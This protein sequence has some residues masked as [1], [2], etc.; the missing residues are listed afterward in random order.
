MKYIVLT[1]KA[2]IVSAL[3]HAWP[4]K[5]NIHKERGFDTLGDAREFAKW[6]A[7]KSPQQGFTVYAAQG[8]AKTESPPV[9]W[10]KST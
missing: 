3:I 2:E 4:S 8:T 1:D 7:A 5:E 6:L 10:T 9:K